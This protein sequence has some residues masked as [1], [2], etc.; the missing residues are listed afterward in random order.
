MDRLDTSERLFQFRIPLIPIVRRHHRQNLIDSYLKC[1][2]N[3]QN[4]RITSVSLNRSTYPADLPVDFKLHNFLRFGKSE[5]FPRG[6]LESDI[7][8][9]IRRPGAPLALG[10]RR[11]R[12][13]G[14][15][16]APVMFELDQM[17]LQAAQRLVDALAPFEGALVRGRLLLAQLLAELE[18][19]EAHTH[20]GYRTIVGGA[21]EVW[22][23]S[24]PKRRSPAETLLT[25]ATDAGLP[26]WGCALSDGV[27]VARS[28]ARCCGKKQGHFFSRCCVFV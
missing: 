24:A 1:N 22:E 6:R 15:D 11:G 19:V 17:V 2:V 27:D 8:R 14:G 28:T 23:A 10:R 12:R 13:R 9:S 18:H 25:F 4:I 21:V 20:R 16:F 26:T 3:K 7:G 5:R